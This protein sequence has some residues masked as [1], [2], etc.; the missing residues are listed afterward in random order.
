MGQSSQL[1]RWP[2]EGAGPPR[3]FPEQDDPAPR[4]EKPSLPS[5]HA[6]ERVGTIPVLS[7]SAGRADRL[8]VLRKG[9]LVA[10]LAPGIGAA[11]ASQA[12]GQ[13]E[14]GVARD[15]DGPAPNRKGPVPSDHTAER[16]CH[17]PGLNGSASRPS[18]GRVDRPQGWLRNRTQTEPS[19][20]HAQRQPRIG[21]VERPTGRLPLPPAG[22]D[23][24]DQDG[25]Q[26]PQGGQ[27]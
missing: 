15:Q 17:R 14:G 23:P 18:A 26:G 22:K 20:L 1:G 13:E 21:A 27:G 4:P 5:D 11:G 24:R 2:W 7:G 3:S 9:P 25:P 8:K 6:A 19:G 10:P 16:C 12:A